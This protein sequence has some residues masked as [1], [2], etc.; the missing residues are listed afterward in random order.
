MKSRGLADCGCGQRFG[1]KRSKSEGLGLDELMIVNPGS[2]RVDGLLL[3]EGGAAYRVE[4][5]AEQDETRGLGR[6]FLGEDGTLYRAEELRHSRSERANVRTS[7]PRTPAS[8]GVAA[9][10]GSPARSYRRSPSR[11]PR[12]WWS[13]SRRPVSPRVARASAR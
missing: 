5:L 11:Q 7:S 10:S 6:F 8:T 9:R 3:G 1:A 4:G 13:T 2:G 12:T